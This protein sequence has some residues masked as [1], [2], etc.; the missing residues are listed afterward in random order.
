MWGRVRAAPRQEAFERAFERERERER[1]RGRKREGG[2]SEKMSH[3]NLNEIFF[4]SLTPV[5]ILS[6]SYAWNT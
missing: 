5:L 4:S 3:G 6:L 1:E 2:E